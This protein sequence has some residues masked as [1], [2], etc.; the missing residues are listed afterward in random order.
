MTIVDAVRA[1][2]SD[3]RL[4]MRRAG[5]KA[6]F[7]IASTYGLRVVLMYGPQSETYPSDSMCVAIESIIAED[8]ETYEMETDRG[9]S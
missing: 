2:M 4:A 9:K 1:C 5:E 8:W 7:R 3:P 6:A